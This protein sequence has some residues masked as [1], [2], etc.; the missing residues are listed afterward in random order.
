MKRFKFSKYIIISL[1]S[2]TMFYACSKNFLTVAPV[3]TLNPD[4]LANQKGVQGLLVGAY[5]I[6]DGQGGNNGGWGSA[7]SN[8][9]YGSVC[10]DEAYK[11]STSDDQGDIVPLETWSANPA[12][13]YPSQKWDVNYDG[14][15]RANQVLRVAKLATDISSTDLAVIQGEA[16]FLRGFYHFELK[17]VFNN[18]PY[19]DESIADT[20]GQASVSNV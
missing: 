6:L 15:Q 11:G 8:W 12:N 1:A 18:I 2:A 7:I 10:A 20:S 3:G 5:S 9:V 16:R 4:I 17:K 14:I 19:V 13:S